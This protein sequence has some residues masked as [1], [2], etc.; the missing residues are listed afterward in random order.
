MYP[1]PALGLAGPLGAAGKVGGLGARLGLAGV[2]ARGAPGG[3]LAR[4]CGAG[5]GLRW[6]VRRGI[7][8]R[9]GWGRLLQL[10]GRQVC[11]RAGRGLHLSFWNWLT[12]A[13]AAERGRQV[14]QSPRAQSCL[15]L[16]GWGL[17]WGQ[18][19]GP[20]ATLGRD[21][22]THTHACTPRINARPHM[23]MRAHTHRPYLPGGGVTYG[24]LR[25]QRGAS[26]RSRWGDESPAA[27]QGLQDWSPRAC[28][29][30]VDS[31]DRGAA[32]AAMSPGGE[33]RGQE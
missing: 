6:G 29:R 28:G 33:R 17:A 20:A 1:R 32:P 3:R 18:L 10:A 26:R 25:G 9:L 23:R 27:G 19:K 7:R 2:G 24:R 14:W 21:R 12:V 22:G 31:E 8:G 16:R 5:G 13:L 4:G 15:Q 11:V 30:E